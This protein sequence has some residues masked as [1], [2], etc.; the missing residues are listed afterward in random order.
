MPMLNGL[1]YEDTVPAAILD[2][3]NAAVPSDCPTPG[4]WERAQ[5]KPTRTPKWIEVQSLDWNHPQGLRA[6]LSY[7]AARVVTFAPGLRGQINVPSRFYITVPWLDLLGEPGIEIVGGPIGLTAPDPLFYSRRD[8]VGTAAHTR[9]I[10]LAC[11]GG[12]GTSIEPKDRRDSWSVLGDLSHFAH[13]KC[14]FGLS[15]DEN[16]ELWPGAAGN[17]IHDALFDGCAFLWPLNNAGHPKGPHPYNLLIGEGCRDVTVRGNLF[18]GAGWRSPQVDGGCES[19]SIER[20]V[21]YH[22]GAWG[23]VVDAR[24][25]RSKQVD[26]YICDNAVIGPGGFLC[27]K[28]VDVGQLFVADNVGSLAAYRRD[29]LVDTT[30]DTT[31]DADHLAIAMAAGAGDRISALFKSVISRWPDGVGAP[32][33]LIDSEADLARFA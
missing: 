17:Q 2:R 22:C 20:N 28:G 8:E 6:A 23:M 1:Y 15:F 29:I 27:T 31:G 14:T 11:F 5:R 12:L 19:I 7:T 25:T 24:D 10:G 21:L 30:L 18:G 33:M 4:A 32:P 26:A 9:I 13:I 16:V 3:I